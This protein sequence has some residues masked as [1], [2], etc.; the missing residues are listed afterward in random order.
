MIFPDQLKYDMKLLTDWGALLGP[1]NIPLWIYQCTADFGRFLPGVPDVY[2]HLTAQ[3]IK[4]V[5]PHCAGM[6]CENHQQTHTYRNMDVYTYMRLLWN[7]DLDIE[8]ELA[9]YFRWYYGPA[10]EPAQKLFE[11]FE[12]NWIRIDRI[13]EHDAGT[14]IKEDGVTYRILAV[15]DKTISLVKITLERP[16]ETS[17]DL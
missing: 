11:T 4:T 8:Q 7:P 12:K 6:Y 2:P 17:G 16:L 14:E 13:P 10:A 3:Y 15:E 9:D 1:K 5:K